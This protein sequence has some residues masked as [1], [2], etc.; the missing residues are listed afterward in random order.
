MMKRRRAVAVVVAFAV[1]LA[2]GPSVVQGD[3]VATQGSSI[4][5]IVAAGRTFRVALDRRARVKG[6]GQSV[7]ATLLEP[8]YAYDRIVVPM[9]TKAQGHIEKLEAVSRSARVHAM[10]GGDF[11]P[12]RITVVQ[13]DNLVLPDGNTLR[14]AA[15]VKSIAENVSRHIAS[16]SQSRAWRVREAAQQQV[17]GAIEPFTAPGKTD[18]LKDWALSRLPY[19]PQYLRKGTVYTIELLEPLNFGTAVA[20]EWAPNGTMPAPDSVVDARL[21]TALDSAKTPRG[22]VIRAVLTR[23]VFS[24]DERLILPEGT[25]LQGEVTFAQKAR[26]FRRNGQL[27]FLFQTVRLAERD[28]E[29]LLAGLHATELSG[30]NVTIDEEGGARMTNPKTRF[31]APVVSLFAARAA[32]NRDIID[33]GEVGNAAPIN[34]ANVGGRALGGF[35]GLGAVGMAVAQISRPVATSLGLVGLGETVYRSLLGKGSEVVF[36]ADTP[37]QLQLSPGST[38]E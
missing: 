29:K 8:L 9:G 11:T 26:R 18:R 37:L 33:A 1:T 4:D 34:G 21:I 15:R 13:F 23:P 14:I 2:A 12:L 5:L 35:F 24:A 27:R 32:T 36:P 31:I 19:H 10:L 22:T 20:R 28:Q 7:T 6:V 38:A 25:E 17:K 30:T 3:E 16:S